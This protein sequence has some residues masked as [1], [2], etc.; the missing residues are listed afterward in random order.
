LIL[1]SRI[2]S[3]T[4]RQNSRRGTVGKPTTPLQSPYLTTSLI[5][6]KRIMPATEK[7]I[8]DIL[9]HYVARPAR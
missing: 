3:P 9:T 8:F 1:L 4:T 5:H 2:Q 7:V 6:Y